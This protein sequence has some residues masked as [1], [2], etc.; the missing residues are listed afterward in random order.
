VA[1]SPMAYLMT[2]FSTPMTAAACGVA[3]MGPDQTILGD[4]APQAV[5]DC[6]AACGVDQ[7]YTRAATVQPAYTLDLGLLISHIMR[8]EQL[9]AAAVAWV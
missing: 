6:L 1:P 9:V 8:C 2:L 4:Y 7:K 3:A 5:D